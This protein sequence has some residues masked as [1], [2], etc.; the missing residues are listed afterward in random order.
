MAGTDIV[1]VGTLA[2]LLFGSGT[3][4]H[5]APEE[6]DPTGALAQPAGFLSSVGAAVW[7]QTSAKD[8]VIALALLLLWGSRTWAA[9]QLREKFQSENRS[10]LRDQATD[11]AALSWKSKGPAMP[12]KPV[13]WLDLGGRRELR[14]VVD[15]IMNLYAGNM[16][17][18][19][20]VIAAERDSKAKAEAESALARLRGSGTVPSAHLAGPE[21][22]PSLVKQEGANVVSLCHVAYEPKIAKAA[23]AALDA[24]PAGTTAILRF[25]SNNSYYRVL[26][27]AWERA[28]FAP[29]R[30]HLS[31]P[32]LIEDLKMNGWSIIG[33]AQLPQKHN[34]ATRD[35]R[36]RLTNWID[37]AY[38]E[39]AADAMAR[40]FDGMA[41]SGVE[42]LDNEDRIV[43]LEKPK[44]L[45][46][47]ALPAKDAVAAKDEGTARAPV[48]GSDGARAAVSE[49]V[50]VSNAE[51]AAVA[52][53]EPPPAKKAE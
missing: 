32:R 31:H 22:W 26:S 24:A 37:V 41:Q 17:A 52:P 19:T 13:T 12:P 43:V 29:W 49:T 48:Q 18:V 2:F 15:L 42:T 14:I 40:Y 16:S 47:A 33:D 46:P 21:R 20:R 6:R 23:W 9:A 39:S 3:N 35:E 44:P 51:S 10:M 30:H 4:L 50:I 28:P 34:I 27:S 25:T 45:Q 8:A 38:G 11:W 7:H 53:V 5:R 1:M 36:M